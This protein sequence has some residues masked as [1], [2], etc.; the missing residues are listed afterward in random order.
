MVGLCDCNNFFVSCQRLFRPDLN[1]RP[2]AVLSGNDGCV[3]ARSNEVKVLGIK[4]G[5]PLYQV[6]DIVHKNGVTL[7][8]ANHKLYSDISQRVMATLRANTQGIEIYSVDEAFIDFSGFSLDR[9]KEHGEQ[10]SALTKRDTGIPVSIGI[11]PTKTLAKI[12]SKLCKQYP[13]L[14]GCCLMYKPA[15]IE[16]VLRQIPIDDVWGIGRKSVKKLHL[17]NVITA[18]DFM[19]CKSD[20]VNSVLHLPGLRTWKELHSIPSIELT[21]D[22]EASQ[23][24]SIGRSFSKDI[25]SQ[26]ELRSIVTSFATTLAAKLRSQRAC[27]SQL[28]TYLHTNRHRAD[29][30]QQHEGRTV[31]F[32]EPTD[33]T[34]DIV[35]ASVDSLRSIY[36]QGFGYKKAGVICSHLHDRHEVQESLFEEED[37]EGKK[38]E[39]LMAAIDKI[40]SRLG[41]H[42]IQMAAEAGYKIDT[43]SEYLSPSFTTRWQDVLL[44]GK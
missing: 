18:Y 12:A 22:I 2:V 43:N 41:K 10:L 31:V 27:V 40:N 37:V 5:V 44:V 14:K 15:D 21:K 34:I 16:K 35:Q 6:R 29:V 11:A 9:L 38:Q 25:Y 42:S 30:R 4:M 33:N 24:I 20:W 39:Q 28:T 3:I 19:Q 32:K 8:S 26:E 17:A 23:S 1:G 7:F 13:A 36:R